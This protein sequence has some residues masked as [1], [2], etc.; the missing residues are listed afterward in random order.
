[1]PYGV[2]LNV[3]ILVAFVLAFI[4]AEEVRTKVVLATIMAVLILLPQVVT[5]TSSSG[6]WWV[7]YIAKVLFGIGC[8]LYVK[9]QGLAF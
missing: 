2:I 9:W 5:M 6:I 7:H 8:V 1:M 4:K 3:A